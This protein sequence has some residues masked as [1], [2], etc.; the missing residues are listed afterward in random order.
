MDPRPGRVVYMTRRTLLI[1]TGIVLVQ[2][3]I[4][5]LVF[6]PQP[7]S[8]GDNA[9]YVS[10]AHSIL[11]RG[12]YLELWDPEEPP[13]TKYPPVFAGLLALAILLGAQSWS[14]LKV[15]PAFSV[16]LAV[17]FTFLW[18]R[19]RKSLA[20]GVVVALLLGIS[21][22]VVYY[23]QW[24]LSDPTFLAFTMAALWALHRSLQT[25]GGIGGEPEMKRGEG[26][27]TREEGRAGA[28]W[29]GLGMAFVVLAYFTRS[30]GL[31]LAVATA[32]WLGLG[33][34][35]KG[36]ATFA[37]ALGVPAILWWVRGRAPGG[38]EYVSEFW[39]V[40]PYQPHLGT[41]GISG[42][43]TRAWENL[44]AYV[45]QII[46]EGVVGSSLSF[47]P[48]LPLGLGLALVALVGWV[49]A[50]RERLG[51]AEIY[52]PLYLGLILLW[53]QAWSGDRFALPL[54]PLA[55][56][57]CGS[58]LGWLLTSYK[59]ETRRGVMAVLVALLAIPAGYHWFRMMEGAGA[60]RDLTR[61]DRSV[62]CLSQGQGEYFALAEWSG[63]NL[64][65]GVSVTTRKPRIFF[66]MSGV[67]AHSIPLVPDP[68][69]FLTQVR[70]S[71][72]RYVSLDFLDMV[73]G[74]YVYPALQNRLSSFCGLVE[75]GQLGTQLLGVLDGEPQP[76]D[77]EA[78]V[79]R[80]CPPGM[81]RE[82]PRERKPTEGWQIPLL[83]WG[84]S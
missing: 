68:D 28:F 21:E 46:P 40:D 8:G 52:F 73:S 42:L 24:I 48:L 10:L 58:A 45:V 9:G 66:L 16:V 60:C 49:R 53:P 47:L 38:S 63:N 80:R 32:L 19:E 44:G 20:M 25:E 81:F 78:E 17:A 84:S 76:P 14:A 72:S 77:T 83:I 74:Y 39:L 36:L 7:H 15:L 67:K 56:F 18:A 43:M 57:Y 27:R 71:G 22:S 37:L 5:A 41:V 4:V 75:V 62:E 3:I 61:A 50:S 34:R 33:R 26:R 1:L 23:S 31:P 55:F 35:W 64:P 6:T 59:E 65:D 30:A 70:G 13:H 51:P 82:E 54:L 11:D 79:L 29:L 12:A 69:Q 2:S